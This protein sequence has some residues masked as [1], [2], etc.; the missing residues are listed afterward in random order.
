MHVKSLQ[1]ELMR[2]QEHSRQALFRLNK[3]HISSLGPHRTG[4]TN[5]QSLHHEIQEAQPN[6]AMESISGSLSQILPTIPLRGDIQ[7]PKMKPVE[8][9]HILH[10]Q[11]SET[12][13]VGNSVTEKLERLY[14]KEQQQHGRSRHRLVT[15]FKELDLLEAPLAEQAQRLSMTKHQKQEAQIAASITWWKCLTK[16]NRI[17]Q[18]GGEPQEAVRDMQHELQN[19]EAD[20]KTAQ[21]EESKPGL[22]VVRTFRDAQIQVDREKNEFRDVA[23]VTESAYVGEATDDLLKALRR[24]EGMVAQA[25][26]AAHVLMDSE[27]KMKERI[28]AI[29]LRVGQV[30]SRAAAIENQIN[31]LEATISANTQWMLMDSW[32]IVAQLLSLPFT[33]QNLPLLKAALLQLHQ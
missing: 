3:Y 24:V 16:E 23:V 21:L 25:M 12:D 27:K 10:T 26:Q 22:R 29:S 17:I 28:E 14:L 11:L 31:A 32:W 30:L 5:H 9:S 8:L 15:L 33:H 4:V 1:S 7:F 19:L 2:L 18:T 6:V 13:K 20:L